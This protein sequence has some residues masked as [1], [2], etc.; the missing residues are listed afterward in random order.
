MPRQSRTKKNT[1]S[2]QTSPYKGVYSRSNVDG[3]KNLMA[4][5]YW[6]D[7]AVHVGTFSLRNT[8]D[9]NNA[10]IARD[11]AIALDPRIPDSIKQLMYNR[12][13][14]PT[15]AEKA[16]FARHATEE[17]AFKNYYGV[18]KIPYTEL[19]TVNYTVGTDELNFGA[20]QTREEAA[21]AFDLVN[22]FSLVKANP[23][24]NFGLPSRRFL[25]ENTS[26]TDRLFFL[27]SQ[28]KSTMPELTRNEEIVALIRALVHQMS[29]LL[30]QLADP[31]LSLISE[32]SSFRFRM[33][34]VAEVIAQADVNRTPNLS[35]T[36]DLDETD[37]EFLQ[38]H[39]GEPTA[40]ELEAILNFLEGGNDHTE[41]QTQRDP[42]SPRTKKRH[43]KQ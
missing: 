13:Q 5:Y 26:L 4:Y 3:S 19:Y 10:I 2:S 27:F 7:Q 6:N 29:A 18:V 22:Y 38:Q 39:V 40:A 14:A 1:E 24:Y 31:M 28:D 15:D 41:D 16:S 34:N 30:K 32:S 17:A 23:V 12:S 21:L 20:F 33:P 43:R 35:P 36:S 9:I 8:E 37:W 11:C 25:T 42:S